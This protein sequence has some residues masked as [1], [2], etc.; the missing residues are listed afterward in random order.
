MS[1]AFIAGALPALGF[2]SLGSGSRG[3]GTLVRIGGE[4][5]LVDCGFSVRVTVARL[6]RF[7]LRPGDLSAILVTHEHADHIGGVAGLAQRYRIPVWCSHGTR[8]AVAGELSARCFLSDQPF[9]IGQV[10]VDPVAVPHDAREPTQFVFRYEAEGRAEQVGVLSDLG[11]ITPHVTDRFS[12][13]DGLMLEAN[14]DPAL[15]RAGRYPPSVKRRVASDLGHLSNEQSLGLLARI[16]H[17][18]LH[19]VLGHISQQNNDMDLLKALF[20]PLR[21][22][23]GAL[24]Y[25]AQETGHR[26]L[27]PGGSADAVVAADVQTQSGTE[28]EIRGETEAIL[29]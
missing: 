25:A 18:K 5:I 8:R 22:Q 26:W 11:C 1:D 20:E 6:A 23:L 12:G 13:C 2:A 7:G 9:S 29:S 10:R 27:C 16:A 14:H 15:L 4:L 24:G 19:V 28:T 21:P 17:P 3:N